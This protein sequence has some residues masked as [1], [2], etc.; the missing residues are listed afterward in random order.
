M[1]TCTR[2]RHRIK[3]KNMDIPD[4]I[5]KWRT[6]RTKE[7]TL[8]TKLH[9][10]NTKENTRNGK[11]HTRNTKENTRDTKEHR[12]EPTYLE[13]IQRFGNKTR[14]VKHQRRHHQQCDT[15]KL[16]TRA[17]PKRSWKTSTE[18]GSPSTRHRAWSR[19]HITQRTQETE[20]GT[21]RRK[22]VRASIEANQLTV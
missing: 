12:H 21:Q 14:D 18:Y 6:R 16:R 4:M 11:E 8:N 22:T 15:Q 3:D 1:N 13:K 10:L 7:H 19:G 5:K 20:I 2:T 17:R 9:A